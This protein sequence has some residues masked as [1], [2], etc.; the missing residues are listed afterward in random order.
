MKNPRE[1]YDLL[2][3]LASAAILL[4]YETALLPSKPT[5]EDSH[6]AFKRYRAALA[7]AQENLDIREIDNG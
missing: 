6:K 3:E 5:I 7:A 4:G 2:W 1:R